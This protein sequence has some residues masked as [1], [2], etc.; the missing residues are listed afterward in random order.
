MGKSIKLKIEAI[1]VGEITQIAALK[2][3]LYAGGNLNGLLK[4]PN[5]ANF[6]SALP[7]RNDVWVVNPAFQSHIA[8]NDGGDVRVVPE[9]ENWSARALQAAI[10][11][12]ESDVHKTVLI[13]AADENRN[14]IVLRVGNISEEE[15]P[16][17]ELHLLNLQANNQQTATALQEADCVE[18]THIQAGDAT[19]KTQALLTGLPSLRDAAVGVNLFSTATAFTALFQWVRASVSIQTRTH[20][21]RL[22][23]KPRRIGESGH[24]LFGGFAVDWAG[25]L[26]RGRESE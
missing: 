6:S 21:G 7:F 4:Q 10:T 8:Q 20:Y 24:T 12:L 18:L 25:L 11:I 3:L 16:A 9:G 2:A 13:A 22:D 14:R 19:E 5:D 23:S 26:S 15:Q 1:Q 17:C